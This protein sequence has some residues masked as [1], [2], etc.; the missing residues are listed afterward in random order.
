MPSAGS[1]RCSSGRARA[2]RSGPPGVLRLRGHG[3]RHHRTEP[4]PPWSDSTSACA[5]HSRGQ[6]PRTSSPG[7]SPLPSSLHRRRRGSRRPRGSRPMSTPSSVTSSCPSPAVSADGVVCRG[8]DVHPTRRDLEARTRAPQRSPPHASW[9]RAERGMKI[10]PIFPGDDERNVVNTPGTRVQREPGRYATRQGRWFAHPEALSRERR[11]IVVASGT[12]AESTDGRK[13]PW[14]SRDVG[15][16]PA[17]AL[18][19]PDAARGRRRGP[20]R[21]RERLVGSDPADAVADD[22]RPHAAP[23]L[24]QLLRVPA[25]R[26]LA[27]RPPAQPACLD[28]VLPSARLRLL[29]RDAPLRPPGARHQARRDR[30]AQDRARS[31]AR[32][33]AF[34]TRRT[35]SR[36]RWAATVS[37]TARC[38]PASACCTR[39]VDGSRYPSTSRPRTARSSRRR[40]GRRSTDTAYYLEHFDADEALVPREMLA[41][42]RPLGLSVPATNANGA[43]TV[44]FCAAAFCTSPRDTAAARRLTFAMLL[45]L[46]RADR[47]PRDRPRRLPAA[48]VLRRRELRR[49]LRAGTGAGGDLPKWRFYQAREYYALALTGM[50]STSAT[51]ASTRAATCGRSRSARVS[52]HVDA[53]LDFA[54]LADLARRR[55]RRGSTP[56][57]PFARPARLARRDGRRPPRETSTGSCGLDSP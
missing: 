35:T 15:D 44:D 16:R 36:S 9:S 6:P 29:G 46:A 56:A 20:P 52:D 21:P 32:L 51:G 31:R 1:M 48:G 25:R 27:P 37:T 45:D 2:D 38:S 57:S 43:R 5:Q 54:A 22:Q 14:P 12:R 7:C 55:Q 17:A 49:V 40:S 18:D 50:W 41:R 23:A 34:D 33:E 47:R 26:V 28:P 39:A 42:V 19:R 10:P 13:L 8:E 3:H 53:A 30:F 24:P 4:A 11:A